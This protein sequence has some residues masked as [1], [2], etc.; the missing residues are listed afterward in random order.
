MSARMAVG[1]LVLLNLLIFGRV[2][3]F[4]FV[5]LDDDAYVSENPRVAQG[6]NGEA[7][8]WAFQADLLFD[9]PHADY[10][11]PVT[12]LSRMLD[13][14]WFGLNPAMHHGVNLMLHLANALLV[15]LL[16][17][18]FGGTMGQALFVAAWFSIHPQ[19]TE[20]VAWVTARKDLLATLFALLTVLA[21]A[22]QVAHPSLLQKGTV[23]GLFSLALM[24]KPMVVT[25]PALLLLLDYWPLR[26]FNGRA[27]WIKG[28]LSLIMEKRWL[29]LLSFISIGITWRTQA[30][31]VTNAS[32]WDALWNVA[33]S[34]GTYG[35]RSFWPEPLAV[36]HAS[37][38]GHFSVWNVGGSFVLLGVVSGWVMRRTSRC[39]AG[40]VGWLW[41]LVAL[42][43]VVGLADIG[44]ADRFTYLPHVG[45]GWALAW[46]GPAFWE[47]RQWPR[48]TLQ[49]LATIGI[50]VLAAFCWRAL[51]PWRDTEHLM[52]H[53]LEVYPDNALAHG[54]LGQMAM[55]AGHPAQAQ[56]LLMEAA[57]LDARY[58]SP[59]VNLGLMAM[60]EKDFAT[61]T[62]FLEEALTLQPF[63]A[64][65][66]CN[67]GALLVSM[68]KP[69]EALPYLERAVRV[70]PEDPILQN[71]LAEIWF[72]L[73]EWER[74]RQGYERSLEL[75][76]KN[77][78]THYN[79]GHVWMMMHQEKKAMEQY[80]LAVEFD[81]NHVYARYNLAVLLIEFG[82]IS[83]GRKELEEVLRQWPGM[84]PALERWAELN[85]KIGVKTKETKR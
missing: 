53:E 21:Y 8:R 2:V 56:A 31:A 32:G 73:G 64:D 63:H 12:I 29:W 42:A 61:A 52:K 30:A 10:W 38:L 33:L 11:A 46:L 39:P 81:P 55:E 71:N 49:G 24:A 76:P 48:W 40:C 80:R 26:R 72:R 74:A 14:Q 36:R 79:L 41:F 82:E 20:V 54:I 78:E 51:N 27:G 6:L 83:E 50:V 4:D 43:P 77:A 7:I 70:N 47:E 25:L 65:A 59:R 45:L 19:H 1:L 62:K 84:P 5:R 58:V 3:E 66:L 13:I 60:R 35:F 22:R 44:T 57:R 16:T 17:R 85:R 28:A 18:K 75:Q 67:K 15:F 34:Y 69:S 68:G 37:F 9:S 23:V